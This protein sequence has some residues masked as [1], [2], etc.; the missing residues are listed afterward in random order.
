MGPFAG[1]SPVTLAVVPAKAGIQLPKRSELGS[2]LRRNDD[3][4]SGFGM[5]HALWEVKA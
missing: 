5:L 2:G 3:S 1:L 4:P